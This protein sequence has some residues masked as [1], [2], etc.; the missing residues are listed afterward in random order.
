MGIKRKRS[1]MEE[2]ESVFMQ[3]ADLK[4]KNV[5]ST[6]NSGGSNSRST[7]SNR[8]KIVILPVGKSIAWWRLDQP[9]QETIN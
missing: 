7:N 4:T 1:E 2:G 8:D 5:L 9:N 3:Q 6:F